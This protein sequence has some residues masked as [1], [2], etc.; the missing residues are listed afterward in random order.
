MTGTN[1]QYT[2]AAF[3]SSIQNV[4]SNRDFEL[5]ELA[6]TSG[7]TIDPQVFK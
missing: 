6:C 4:L 2:Q 7:V 1:Q 3:N 5:Y